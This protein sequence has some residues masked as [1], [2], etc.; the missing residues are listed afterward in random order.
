MNM[1]KGNY[2]IN[3]ALLI[4]YISLD[5]YGCTVHKKIINEFSIINAVKII[6]ISPQ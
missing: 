6:I 2:D 3:N 1:K 4:G 5:M